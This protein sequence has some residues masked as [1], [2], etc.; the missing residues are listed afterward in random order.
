[1]KS[2]FKDSSNQ[3]NHSNAG[4]QAYHRSLK[5]KHASSLLALLMTA[6]FASITVQAASASLCVQAVTSERG[7]RYD[8]PT[9]S[10]HT[11]NFDGTLR[12][13]I[14]REN[15]FISVEGSGGKRIRHFQTRGGYIDSAAFSPDNKYVF[16]QTPEFVSVWDIQTGQLVS[17]LKTELIYRKITFTADS[18][19]LI[20]LSNHKSAKVLDLK[21]LKVSFLKTAIGDSVRAALAR[22]LPPEGI[23]ISDDR[24]DAILFDS[25]TGRQ[26]LRVMGN[27][28]VLISASISPGASQ[29]LTVSASRIQVVDRETG[30]TQFK[31]QQ[32]SASEP[33]I[34]AFY[35]EHFREVFA[36]SIKSVNV[37]DA[38]DGHV[39][40]Q[41]G[42]HADALTGA[43]LSP[44][45][46]FILTVSN[47]EMTLWD[48]ETG[49]KARALLWTK[50]LWPKLLWL[51]LL[52]P[53]LFWPEL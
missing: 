31:F 4:A 52:W 38:N 36:V 51:K 2:S 9:Q 17:E 14:D 35:N 39:L 28:D 6:P 8:V 20:L 47:Q 10:L 50:L 32:T 40:M 7:S 1:M 34:N 33:F 15:A 13:Q 5:M 26:T 37:L 24:R 19:S 41:L 29:V 12:L 44:D 3:L 11:L 48:S 42:G 46:K 23:R 16:T 22:P 30:R 53:K 18:K 25:R 27:G 43:A 45:G 49:E 21:T